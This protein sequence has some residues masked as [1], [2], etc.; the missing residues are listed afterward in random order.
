MD[1]DYDN[2]RP[3]VPTFSEGSQSL[4]RGA[5]S[6]AAASRASASKSA[7]SI[8]S[9]ASSIIAA[10]IQ[11]ATITTTIK[12][13]NR[14]FNNQHR[15]AALN[16]PQFNPI[17]HQH[18]DDKIPK[19]TN[20]IPLPR[21]LPQQHIIPQSPENTKLQ[22]PLMSSMNDFIRERGISVS[23][24]K[25]LD[26]NTSTDETI[27]L[28]EVYRTAI[29]LARYRKMELLSETEPLIEKCVTRY[30]PVKYVIHNTLTEDSSINEEH[31]KELMDTI[32]KSL[33]LTDKRGVLDSIE[34]YQIATRIFNEE[35]SH[36]RA[37]QQ[38]LINKRVY[39]TS[40]T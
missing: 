38:A 22:T 10:S 16:T 21:S 39:L 1:D 15:T 5:N 12:P 6:R 13:P 23:N 40:D 37:F 29:Q 24:K 35:P 17:I 8:A 19:I 25:E 27:R 34:K 3:H 20:P 28:E 14:I 36:K 32:R 31:L 11:N 18:I 2:E 4:K 26:H 9:K 30:K 33:T 7:I